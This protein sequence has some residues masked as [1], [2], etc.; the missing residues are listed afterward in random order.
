MFY[1]LYLFYN[2]KYVTVNFIKKYDFLIILLECF[3]WLLSSWRSIL[4]F[5]WK[6]LDSESFEEHA[7]PQYCRYT[8]YR[9]FTFSTPVHCNGMSLEGVENPLSSMT[10]NRDANCAKRAER[11]WCTLGTQFIL[12]ICLVCRRFFIDRGKKQNLIQ[13]YRSE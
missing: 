11:K 13:E 5:Q 3:V 4:L 10:G 6:R 1:K 12:Y 8:T 7:R 2:S 9:F